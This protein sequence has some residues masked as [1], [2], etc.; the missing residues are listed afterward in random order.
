ML[1]LA[2]AP[3]DPNKPKESLIKFEVCHNGPTKSSDRWLQDTPLTNHRVLA[4]P[5]VNL[6]RLELQP[7]VMI[8]A[9]MVANITVQRFA[10]VPSCLPT[11]TPSPRR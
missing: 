2:R 9:S 1:L 8:P 5:N 10:A 7:R 11:P 4:T 6:G 3:L